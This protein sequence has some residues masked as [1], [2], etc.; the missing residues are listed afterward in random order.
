MSFP[1]FPSKK[2][3]PIFL[4]FILMFTVLNRH[5]LGF[6]GRRLSHRLIQPDSRDGGAS[7]T[8]LAAG[9]DRHFTLSCPHPHPVKRRG[10]AKGE[11]E[12]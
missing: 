8:K 12:M 3:E 7:Q 11:V 9:S 5:F 4:R 1:P 10:K 6:T 2:S